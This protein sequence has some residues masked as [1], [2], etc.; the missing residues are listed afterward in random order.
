MP[1]GKTSVSS[2][3]LTLSSDTI[4]LHIDTK[5]AAVEKQL[6]T[7]FDIFLLDLQAL[8]ATSDTQSSANGAVRAE[9]VKSADSRRGDRQS[10][11]SMA[12][13]IRREARSCD[14]K[15]LIIRVAVTSVSDVYLHMEMDESYN[16]TV[17]SKYWV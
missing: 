7:A 13:D 10:E 5:F 1:T 15:K 2:R 12:E 6:Q 9:D 17:A 3:S 4:A 8:E 11:Q 14:I 16:L